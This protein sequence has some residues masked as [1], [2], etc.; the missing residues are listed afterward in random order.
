MLAFAAAARSIWTISGG[1]VSGMTKRRYW[2]GTKRAP[3][4]D[5][6]F[7]DAL[8]GDLWTCG[9]EKDWDACWQ[10]GM[11]TR[12]VFKAMRPGQWINHIPGNHALTIK[13]RLYQSLD[14]MRRR[15]PQEA[16][17]R[18][19]FFPDNYL[20][21][22]DY[23][24]LQRD[25]FANPEKRWIIKPKS[26]S[27]G[28]GIEV[29]P[30]AGA[31]P[32][33]EKML[34][35]AYL[36]APH[37]FDG[38]K[39][40]LRCYLAITSVEP[41]RVY[42][43]N[44]GFVKLASEPYRD[45]DFDNLYAHLTNP[46]VNALNDAADASVVFHSFADY[47]LWLKNQGADPAPI[48]NGLRDIG[49][50]AAIAAREHMREQLSRTGAW[51]PG[52]CE[53]IGMDCMIDKDLKPWLL[54]C[55]L[56][57]SLDV[58]ADP[59]SGGEMEKEIKRAVVADLVAMAGLNNPDTGILDA[60]DLSAV[61]AASEQEQER[62]G[63]FE[64]IFPA[65]DAADFYPFFPAPRHADIALAEAN[66]VDEKHAYQSAAVSEYVF[67]DDL[68]LHSPGDGLKS[69]TTAGAYIW[70]RASN[71]EGD[72]EIASDLAKI[73]GATSNEALIAVRETLADWGSA[74][75]LLPAGT[76]PA[77]I[78]AA[79]AAARDWA[80]VETLGFAGRHYRIRYAGPEIAARVSPLVSHL[81]VT[82]DRHD[83]ETEI[84]I[85]RSE[86]G[87]AVAVG[88]RLIA[89]G[90]RLSEIAAALFDILK[91]DAAET[92]PVLEASLWR[93][94]D[95]TLMIASTPRS[96]W[97]C[98][99]V[100][101]MA[102]GDATLIAGVSALGE[103]PGVAAALNL[104]ARVKRDDVTPGPRTFFSGAAKRAAR[105]SRSMAAA[106]PIAP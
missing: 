92:A 9:D 102:H 16:Q 58:C 86:I 69:P 38:R 82:P 29:I 39:Y 73:S 23:H 50:I 75:L 3:A 22:T 11:P 83:G 30:D 64:R 26:L 68:L 10:T 55:N 42:L 56:S 77:H 60:D 21:P 97:D 19:G 45:D 85:M 25:A 32:V 52:C 105:L 8:D 101:A 28:R 62:A 49:V 91:R 72:A 2:T 47:R 43:Y 6:F 4:Q 76:T 95:K 24:A 70:L 66:G 57:P 71:G 44:E 89:A 1:L 94:G 96:R 103:R 80:T 5:R 93:I 35:Q 7:I 18:L 13:S 54:E 53:L 27:R 33:D 36:G 98:L 78:E 88:A 15:A 100:D 40:V 65:Y 63:G 84:L 51:A 74:G 104:P 41:L 12:G 87:Y 14:A 37:L 99:G 90:L 48:F 61:I 81:R 20:M 46:D 59:D 31:A 106:T 79:P 34:V 17:E 67:G